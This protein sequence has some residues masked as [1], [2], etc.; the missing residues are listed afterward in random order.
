M[1]ILN[2]S[3][4]R[5]ADNYTIKY[6]PISSTDLMERA[7][8]LCFKKIIKLYPKI[9]KTT[10][11]VGPGNNGG[12]GL[13]IARLLSQKKIKVSVVILNFNDNFSDDFKVNFERLKKQNKSKIKFIKN[14]SELPKISKDNLIIDAIFGSGLSRILKGFVAEVVNKIN[15]SKANIISIDIPSGLFGEE[16]TQEEKTVVNAKHTLTFQYPSL[17]FMFPENEKYVGKFYILN[18]GIHED[19]INKTDTPYYYIQKKDIKLNKR[20]KFSH[21]GTYGHSMIFAGSYGKAGAAVLC[22]KAAQRAGAGL[23]SATVPECN[24][25]ILQISSPETMLHI[26]KSKLYISELP[27]LYKFNAV[28]IGPGIG[29]NDETKQLLKDLISTYKNPIVFDADAITILSENKSWLKDIPSNSIFTPHPKE[30]ERLVG[31]SKN[32]FER[33]QKQ[34]DFA[35]KHCVN[36]LLKGANTSVVTP[37]GK[38]FFNSTGNPGMAT[39]GSGDVLTGIIVSLLSQ[40]YCPKNAAIIGAYIH[41]VSGDIAEKKIGQSALIASDIINNLGLAFQKTLTTLLQDHYIL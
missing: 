33:L 15:E 10:V 24:Y 8:N 1:K 31:K 41:G 12:D 18:I 5:G 22:V 20:N 19:F 11:F 3:K 34:I 27:D 30:F 26:N 17:S 21:K 40:N 35:K 2:A 7:G 25:E 37:K 6:E 4:T 23:V 38:V 29:F 13:V 32:N 36:V 39:A 16:N 14:I 28:A 9:K